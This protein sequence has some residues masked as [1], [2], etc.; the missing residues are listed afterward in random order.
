MREKIKKLLLD[1]FDNLSE[2]GKATAGL[3]SI[4]FIAYLF[5]SLLKICGLNPK[6]K[7]E[8]MILNK[9]ILLEFQKDFTDSP[10]DTIQAHRKE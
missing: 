7:T 1:W 3:L 10:I 4:I 6:T 2:K 5:I 8:D 9:S